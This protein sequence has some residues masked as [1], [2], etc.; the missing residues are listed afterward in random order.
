M[1]KSSIHF[2][3]GVSGSIPGEIMEKLLV[4]NI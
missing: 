2:A 3:K 4:R 1:D